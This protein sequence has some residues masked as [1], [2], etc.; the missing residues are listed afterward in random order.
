MSV[1]FAV[2]VLL[3]GTWGYASSPLATMDEVQ[4]AVLRAIDVAKA[5]QPLQLRKFVLENLN[6]IS[7]PLGHADDGRSLSC[8]DGRKDQQATGN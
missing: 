8:S 4:K 5:S 1:G 7:G 2:R 3:D 6:G